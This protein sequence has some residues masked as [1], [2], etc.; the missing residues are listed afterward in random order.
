MS[1]TKILSNI[2][3][4]I[5]DN[6]DAGTSDLSETDVMAIVTEI[7]RIVENNAHMSKYQ[8]SKFFGISRTTFD[9]LVAIGVIPKG[10]KIVGF[11][12]LIWTK[13]ELQA[14]A[15]NVKKTLR[16]SG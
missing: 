2:L 3:R 9:R 5:C 12:E 8:A 13:H 7:N 1:P 14:C 15:E 16:C 6:L 4:S 10:R 11:K